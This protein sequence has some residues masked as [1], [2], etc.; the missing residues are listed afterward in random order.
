MEQ[1]RT[2]LP[3]VSETTTS[4]RDQV[5]QECVDECRRLANY[6]K[7]Q[8]SDWY[9]DHIIMKGKSLYTKGGYGS[10]QKIYPNPYDD[11][12]QAATGYFDAAR[13]LEGM[14]DVPPP[15]DPRTAPQ[16]LKEAYP[17]LFKDI[18]ID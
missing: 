2:S 3:I 9:R 12:I 15:K 16:I 17:E 1:T 4:I 7:N 13:T 18:K 5:I 11:Y 10:V 14:M 6:Y 8:A